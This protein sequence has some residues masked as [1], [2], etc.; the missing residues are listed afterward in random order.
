M[1]QSLRLALI[2]LAF[3]ANSLPTLAQEELYPHHFNLSKVQLLDGELKTAMDLNFQAL[4]SYDMDRLLTPFIRQAGLNTGR[5]K[6]WQTAHPNFRNWGGDNFDLS[7][8]V[9]GHYLSA[10]AMG[11]AACQDAM[12]KQQLK[13]RMDYMVGVLKDCQEAFATDA[14]G[15]K[16]F[17][18]GQPINSVWQQMSQGNLSAFQNVRGW[19][20]F[21]CQH[22]VMA[23]LRDAAIYANNDTARELFRGMADWA[24]NVV[25]KLTDSQMQSML[26]T[27][28]GG[29]NEVMADAMRLFGEGRYYTAAKKYSHRTMVSGMQNLNTTFLDNRHANTQVPKYIGFERTAEE[30]ERE[31]LDDAIIPEYTTA[32]ENFW[33][34][35]AQNRT[36]CIGGN[37][38]GEH[39]LA[40]ANSNRYI[41][42]LD[43]P[44]SCNTNNMLK[45]SEMLADRMH[46]AR[47]ADFYEYATLNHIL[48]TQDPTTGGYV[49]FTTLRP[50]GY[51]IY[52]QPNQ[53]M[54]CC[55]GTGM[56]NHSKYG[57]FTYTHDGTDVLY[58]NLFTPSRLVD[59]RFSLTQETK[60]PYEQQTQLTIDADGTYTLA[61][62]HPWWTTEEYKI[63][64]NGIVQDINV[65]RGE[66]SYAKIHRTWK[67]GDVIQVQIPMELR[68]VACP[69]YNDYVAFE[70]GPV[71]LG[72]KTTAENQADADSTGLEWEKL[73]N[74]Y[75]GDGRM[76]H[77][78]GSMAQSKQLTTA[79]LLIGERANVLQRIT[80]SDSTRL[81][82]TIDASRPDAPEYKW[83]KLT[84][85]PFASI[86]HARYMCYWYQQTAENFAKS[87]MAL[88]E[89][90]AAA[91]AAR[92]IDF[93]ATGEQQSEAGHE[94]NY[95][96]ESTS[97]SYN[98]ETYRD[99]GRN[100]HIQYSLFNPEGITDSLS[101]LL[102]FTTADQ[103]RQATLSVDGVKIADITIP[104]TMKGAVNG[105]YN[106]EYPIPATLAVDAEGNAKQKFVVR[107]AATGA[108]LCPGLYYL[109][110]MRSYNAQ[111]NA[112]KWVAENWTTGDTGRLPV[113]R[114][115]Y[116]ADNTLIVRQSGSNNV[117][118]MLDFAKCDYT[119]Q[120]EQKYL[121]IIGS[122]L[123]TGS[124]QNYLWWLN[125]RNRGTQVPP[126]LVRTLSLSNGTTQQAIAWDMTKSGIA[127]NIST[128]GTTDICA[129]QTIFGLTST[130][131][132]S[133][134]FNIS[135][136]QDI[137]VA[138]SVKA[139]SSTIQNNDVYDLS[140]RR[141]SNNTERGIHIVNQKK[142][143]NSAWN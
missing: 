95:S 57:H 12:V 26:D 30:A 115:T 79:P 16:G 47:Y 39:F 75:A 101:V 18:G 42:H 4:L 10:L 102:R 108:T 62:R 89:Q 11:Y 8:H 46:D 86:H 49:Y 52:S 29:M 128:T 97:G 87:D 132:E 122:N 43:G 13:E 121:L 21:Y 76:D 56:E 36:T 45:L 70:Y 96:T 44:E 105:F 109:R 28:H 85:Q 27:E 61:L 125:G 143:I 37:S 60:Y 82:F 131:G 92:T 100:G 134:I 72:A 14:T 142:V 127:E 63:L 24:A 112:Y 120:P 31:L 80:L 133:T 93:V 55:V 90:R 2:S 114:I 130:T 5:Y 135:F 141:I 138:T 84:L 40:K 35:V 74:E 53:G 113:N 124:G 71:L 33:Y 73:Q 67:K 98:N 25:D 110:L 119:I 3:S 17:I 34:D 83:G 111:S 126:T 54:W 51:R 23:G 139:L 48:S 1:K 7:G 64:V 107:L 20:P 118:L 65:K 81:R 6:D 88:E 129:G 15:L 117:C 50:Q 22:K 123:G 94:Y 78:P 137:D 58:V 140:G 103:G 19:V 32:A 77:A 41:D 38:V 68:T 91:L 116:N 136:V 9:G 99:A 59:E 106:V 104:T 66:A 69:N